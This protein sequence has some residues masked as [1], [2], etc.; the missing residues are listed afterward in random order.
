MVTL[1]ETSHVGHFF[2][3]R[4]LQYGAGA[5]MDVDASEKAAAAIDAEYRMIAHRPILQLCKETIEAI[6]RAQERQ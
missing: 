2:H 3:W 1:G 6:M 5:A 4:V